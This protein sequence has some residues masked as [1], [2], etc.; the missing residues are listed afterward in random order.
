MKKY[1]A[2]FVVL[3]GNIGVHAQG[4]IDFQT[5]LTTFNIA[6]WSPNVKTPS[7]ETQGN[8]STD[9]PVGNTTYTGVPL[10]GSSIGSGP[11]GYGNGNDYTIG[12]YAVPGLNGTVSLQGTTDL[13]ATA[14][15]ATTGGTGAENVINGAAGGLAGSWIGNSSVVIPGGGY[16]ATIELAAWYN[17]GATGT[18]YS[19]YS[20]AVEA[21][22][23]AG[24][25]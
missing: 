22:V 9:L 8:T 17:G 11:F 12:L 19:T 25:S 15:F 3:G 2:L 5:Y 1:I 4:L 24:Y 21:G 16:T 18:A 13:I 6:V 23:P 7:V 14:T 20:A 10:G